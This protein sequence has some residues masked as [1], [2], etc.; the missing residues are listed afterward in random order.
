MSQLHRLGM[1]EDKLPD[2]DWAAWNKKR[3]TQAMIAKYGSDDPTMLSFMKLYE[4]KGWGKGSGSGSAIQR[5]AKSI[6]MLSKLLPLLGV[7]LLLDFPCGDQQWAPQLRKSIPGLKYIGADIMPGLIQRNIETYGS[8]TV[9]FMLMGLSKPGAF[10]M[11]QETS[12][13]WTSRD[14]VAVM[15][16]STTPL[17]IVVHTSPR[18]VKAG[19]RISLVQC[20]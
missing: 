14:V 8:R 10:P 4:Q 16:L 20:I 3:S 6:V 2:E 17:L 12:H 9:D 19:Q 5:S 1:S 15:L 7:T 11:L 13:A 18:C